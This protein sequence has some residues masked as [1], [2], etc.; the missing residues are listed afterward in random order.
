ME[1]IS[2]N[3][4][5]KVAVELSLDEDNREVIAYGAFA[6]MQ[7][8]FSV[9]LVFLFG[10][11]FHVAFAAIIISFTAAILRKYSGGV[12][13]SSPG[14]CTFIGIIVS[15][16]P[17]V[18]ISLLISGVV[19]LKSTIILGVVIFIWSYYTIY[20]LVP[21][22]SIAKPIVKE[23]KRNRMKKGSIILLSAYLG[24]TVFLILLYI[25]NGEKK[26]VF[27]VL[28][29]YSGILW[30]VFTLTSLGHLLVGK[31]D[32]FLNHIIKKRG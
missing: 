26:L 14:N 15:V 23:E 5:N 12:H 20:K 10:L 31:V 27:Y 13:A 2:N 16:G 25:S 21:V 11:L 29:L 24:I 6:L 19:N 4:A 30:Q 22:D 7:T 1:K 3:I 8:F 17:A 18:L 9:I 32:H 28:C